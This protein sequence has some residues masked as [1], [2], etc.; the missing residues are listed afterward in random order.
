VLPVPAGNVEQDRDCNNGV[1]TTI[2]RNAYDAPSHE[3]SAITWSPRA[4]PRPGDDTFWIKL[5]EY[6]LI[7]LETLTQKQVF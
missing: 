1:G 2:L 5:L 6:A 7:S 4:A 3:Q